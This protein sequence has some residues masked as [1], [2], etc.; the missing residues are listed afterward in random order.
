MTNFDL[1]FPRTAP[2][3]VVLRPIH[4]LRCGAYLF[5]AI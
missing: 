3:R 5:D 1:T 2:L 4:E